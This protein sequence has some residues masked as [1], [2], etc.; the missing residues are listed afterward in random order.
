MP[1][2][3]P[4]FLEWLANIDHTNL[5]MLCCLV[6]FL[7]YTFR[8]YIFA[9]IDKRFNTNFSEKSNDSNNNTT[10]EENKEVMSVLIELKT[11]LADMKEK[12]AGIIESQDHLQKEISSF[13][14]DTH[15]RMNRISD[16]QEF[17]LNSDKE[18]KKA[19]ITRE[20]NYFYISLKKI[21]LY[22][23]ETIEKIYELY[24]QEN[25]D[26][27]VAGM[28]T[29]IRSLEVVPQITNEDLIN[30]GLTTPRH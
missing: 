26:T 8:P 19:Y 11:E 7:L 12:Q 16:V 1:E 30:A 20:Y 23:R 9:I 21:D 25:G 27:F 3:D 2:I 28:M 4:T 15:D 29:A 17:L 22:S 14:K 24:L 13:K 6:G 18:D 10:K 5:G